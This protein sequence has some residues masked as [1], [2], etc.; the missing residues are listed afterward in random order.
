ME[1]QGGL[2]GERHVGFDPF[3]A[4]DR[5]RYSIIGVDRVGIED[6]WGTRHRE[7]SQLFRLHRRTH[8]IDPAAYQG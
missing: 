8:A 1:V 4:P 7:R 2:G 3:S 6:Q 5:N